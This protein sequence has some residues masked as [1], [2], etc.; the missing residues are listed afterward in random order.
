M[1][2]TGSAS[3]RR[4]HIQMRCGSSI[5]HC[6]LLSDRTHGY[7]RG[8]QW[9]KVSKTGLPLIPLSLDCSLDCLYDIFLWVGGVPG[10]L[11]SCLQ[12]CMIWVCGPP[13]RS[14]I[15]PNLPNPASQLGL[16]AVHLGIRVVRCPA[17][18][19]LSDAHGCNR[20]GWYELLQPCLYVVLNV[21]VSVK[22]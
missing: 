11:W 17:H 16:I 19:P 21:G 8:N 22:C 4:S 20:V 12:G 10:I 3:H 14:N 5:R 13:H 15:W 7:Q 6:A 18:R 9:L 1:I 2:I